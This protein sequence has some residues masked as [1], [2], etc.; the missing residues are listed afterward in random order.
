VIPD[1]PKP[2]KLRMQQGEDVIFLKLAMAVKI[3]MQHEIDEGEIH[4][5]DTLMTEYLC[6][7][8][9]VSITIF[10]IDSV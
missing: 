2:P 3:Y 8:K 7:Y 6:D 9:K 1:P 10:S 4:R 5:A